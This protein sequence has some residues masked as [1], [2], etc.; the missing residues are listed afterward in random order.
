MKKQL[1]LFA[2]ISLPMIASA[3]DAYIDGI[4]YN[5]DQMMKTATVTYRDYEASGN[6]NQNAYSGNVNIPSSVYYNKDSYSVTSIGDWAFAGCTDITG[7]VIPNS[8]MSIGE[9]A[10]SGCI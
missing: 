7:I 6:S 5:F 9:V 3:Y 8:V 4:Y 2:M 10:F 1:L